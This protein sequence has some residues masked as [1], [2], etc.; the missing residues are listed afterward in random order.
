VYFLFLVASFCWGSR[1]WHFGLL[2]IPPRKISSKIFRVC[3][4]HFV[5]FPASISSVVQS[6]GLR[7]YLN[8][9]YAKIP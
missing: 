5:P 8:L 7:L 4:V 3:G 6:A 2:L 9:G 1:G